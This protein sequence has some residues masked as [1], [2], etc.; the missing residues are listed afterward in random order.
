MVKLIH[1]ELTYKIRGVLM[2]VHYE[3]KPMLLEDF[4][5]GRG[6]NRIP[7]SPH[8]VRTTEEH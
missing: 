8:P 1:A 4:L 2:A 6:R 5:S 3:L 7:G